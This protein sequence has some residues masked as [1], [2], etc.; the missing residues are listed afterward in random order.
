M[1]TFN[2]KHDSW[3]F[4]LANFGER[5]VYASHGTD[6]CSY[7]RSV[8]IGTFW[9]LFVATIG[10]GL[11]VVALASFING[12]GWL[13]FGYELE[14]Y[15]RGF[16]IFFGSL[17]GMAVLLLGSVFTKETIENKL[18]EAKPGFVRLAYRSWKDK[19][20]AKVEFE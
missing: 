19:F 1:M 11:A 14:E 8:L 6:I 16:F 3:H 10:V 18:Q 7:V 9:F 17:I 20:C 13:L 12:I 15:A 5:R 4:W 2:L